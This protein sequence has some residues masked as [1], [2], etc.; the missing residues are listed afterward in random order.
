MNFKSDWIA[1]N[2]VQKLGRERDL[3]GGYIL[4]TD[5]GRRITGEV[6]LSPL[7]SRDGYR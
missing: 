6:V 5:S 1:K 3:S 7:Y 4:A 2:V